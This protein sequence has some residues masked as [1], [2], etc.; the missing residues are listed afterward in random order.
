MPSPEE[1]HK[2]PCPDK[3]NLKSLQKDLAKTN[4]IYKLQES[5][6]E[7]LRIQAKQIEQNSQNNPKPKKESAPITFKKLKHDQ[8]PISSV[9]K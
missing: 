4:E 5:K 1:N 7:H 6:F 2:K 9:N 3:S 8:S